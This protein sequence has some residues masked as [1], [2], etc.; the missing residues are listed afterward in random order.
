MTRVLDQTKAP[1]GLSTGGGW[2]ASVAVP[3]YALPGIWMSP[4]F[5]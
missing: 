3:G 4:S 2:S 5:G 1:A